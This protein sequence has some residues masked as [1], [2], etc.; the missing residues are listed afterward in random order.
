[1]NFREHAQT[2]GVGGVAGGF[3]G[4]AVG[5]WV[6]ID[7]IHEA[8][9]TIDT[10]SDSQANAITAAIALIGIPAFIGAGAIAGIAASSICSGFVSCSSAIKNSLSTYSFFN[11]SGRQS[12][13]QH[14]TTNNEFNYLPND[15]ANYGLES[16]SPLSQI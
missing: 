1:M 4:L 8:I 2:L 5:V 10:L 3:T 15:D 9:A 14:M 11:R 7:F 16:A 13:D 6:H 12:L